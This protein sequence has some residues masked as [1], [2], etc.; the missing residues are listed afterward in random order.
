[1][2]AILPIILLVLSGC[3]A[4]PFAEVVKDVEEAAQVAEIVEKQLEQAQANP[5]SQKS[6]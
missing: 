6:V 5:P 2:K 4:L 3:A 1:M